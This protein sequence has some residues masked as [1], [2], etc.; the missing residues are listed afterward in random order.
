MAKRNPFTKEYV[1]GRKDQFDLDYT[2]F[3]KCS[4]EATSLEDLNERLE[5][6]FQYMISRI[7]GE[8]AKELMEEMEII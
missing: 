7:A 2:V 8:N 5:R 6:N 1:T 4:E 3:R